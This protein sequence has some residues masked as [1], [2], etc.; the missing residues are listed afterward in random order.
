MRSV[1]LMV[2]LFLAAC[3]GEAR[4]PLVAS[5]I[6]IT[7]PMPGRHMS[8]GYISFTN[9]RNIVLRHTSYCA[10]CTSYTRI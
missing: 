3:G 8:A 5:D 4:A 6:V 7:E 10:S 9:Y 2:C 1:A